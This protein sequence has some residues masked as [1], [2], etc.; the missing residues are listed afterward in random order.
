[1][2]TGRAAIV[3]PAPA[4][5]WHEARSGNGRRRHTG[6]CDLPPPRRRRDACD[7]ACAHQHR[8]A[9]EA[10]VAAIDA[11]GGSAETWTCD[12]T[13]VAG[14][15]A[16]LQRVLA[17]GVPQV[18]VHSAGIHDDVPLAGMSEQQWRSRHRCV[19]ARLLSPSRGRYCC[20]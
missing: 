10:V 20:R 5:T 7:C 1:M 12:L 6:R 2:L 9:A 18:L 8:A 3:L 4:R 13:D 19:A 16:A 14:T 11:A 17:D 15:E